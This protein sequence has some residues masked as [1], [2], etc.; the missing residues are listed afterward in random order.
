MKKLSKVYSIILII[1]C[2][3]TS[4]E[5]QFEDFKKDDERLTSE[6]V[7]AKFFFPSTQTNLYLPASWNYL[8]TNIML[9]S[10]NGGYATF[11][12][13]NSWEQPDVVFNV[14]RS[15][16]A[17]GNDWN[18]FSGYFLTIDGFLRQVRPGGNL[19]NSLMEAVGEI[20]KA[21][22]FSI[23]TD[24]WGEL[25][26]S[27]VGQEG[28]LTPKFNTQEDIY[29]GLISKLDDAMATIGSNVSTGEGNEDLGE[30]DLMFNGD[31]QK[32]KAYANA[33]KLRIALRA[34]GA[35]GEDFADAAIT[36]ALSN[37]LPTETISIVKD[38]SANVSIANN[39]G[40]F[41]NFDGALKM[42][43]DRFVNVLQDNNDP[44]LPAFADPIPG[45]TVVFENYSETTNKTKV[46]YLLENS[47]DRAGVDYTA[48]TSG[49]NLVVNI[50]DGEHYVGMPMRFV[51]G[52][53]THLHA[54]LFSRQD[55]LT[56]GSLE[57][58][59]EIDRYIMTLAE[60]H[61]MKAE[62]AVLGF[63]GNAQASFQAGIQA[64]L[65]QWGVS[66]NGY[67]DS[68][69]GTLSGSQAEQLD[70]IGLQ[71]W[72]AAFMVGYQGFAIAR[73]FDIPGITDDIPNQPELFS[74]SHPLGTKFPQRV[75]YRQAAYDL[76]GANL[77]EAISRQ[78]PDDN[79]TVL[80]FAKG[81]KL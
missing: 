77:E 12:Y 49:E 58:G 5:S 39:D 27:E 54:Q 73:D 1:T 16:G 9:G 26:Y 50:S 28:I 19:E 22:Y 62:A 29:I 20:M 70:Q 18:T 14:T 56:E 81:S 21:S 32:W 48:N 24:L 15:W 63:G 3:F 40:W 67:L 17:S 4:C 52:M 51:D 42:L 76:N 69:M 61:F 41:E 80:W 78:G 2:V 23:Y 31:L 72:L 60:I 79:A 47:L 36:S 53:K 38:L 13:K 75:K 35:P 46:D 8:F 68:P 59:Q 57:I 66:D 65:D 33:L 25:P 34:K 37:P 55:I 64:S 74:L 10:A 11:G 45:G 43:S 6:D 30:Y 44:R 71:S 7:S